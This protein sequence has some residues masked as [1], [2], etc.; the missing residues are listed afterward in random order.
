MRLSA[1]R[2]RAI[3]RALARTHASAYAMRDRS[4]R[5]LLEIPIPSVYAIPPHTI[6]IVAVMKPA[7]A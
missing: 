1:G 4:P 5:R 2:I 3:N 7:T 6:K